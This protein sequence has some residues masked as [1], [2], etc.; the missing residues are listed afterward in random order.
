MTTVTGPG[1]RKAA[2]V[3]VRLGKDRAAQV[4]AHMSEEEV[5]AISAE[6]AQLAAVE[7]DETR[8]VMGEFSALL[9]ARQ[10]LLQGGMDLAR[11]LLQRSLGEDRAEEAVQRLNAKAIQLPFQFLHRADPAQLRSFISDEH[12]QVIALVLVHMSAEK[13][14]LVLSGLSSELQAEVAHR[15]AVMDRANP[16]TVR[17][18]ESVLERRL[19]SVL[20]PSDSSRVGGLGPLVSIINRADRST[21]R[22]IVDGL[23]SLD[24]VL[25]EEVRSRMFMFEDIVGLGDRDVQQVLRQVESAELALALKGVGQDVRDK[26]TSN[27]SERAAENVLEEVELLGPVRLTQVEEAQQAVIRTIRALEERGDIVVRRGGDDEFVE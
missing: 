15:I 11:D 4:L 5:E 10:H 24:A 16:D 27:L 17:V 12:P 8:D 14:S 13:A 7:P 3:L 20:Q 1:A 23:E 21:E 9:N 6:I 18:V 26:I 22:Q 25:A 2:I 19:S